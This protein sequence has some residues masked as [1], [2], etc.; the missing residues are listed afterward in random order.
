MKSKKEISVKLSPR[1]A[2]GVLVILILIGLA[3]SNY[4]QATLLNRLQ[5]ELEIQH[6]RNSNLQNR[7]DELENQV[8]DLQRHVSSVDSRV[9]ELEYR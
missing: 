3:F 8:Q 5:T 2:F 1:L 9:D 4:H 6:G 7:V